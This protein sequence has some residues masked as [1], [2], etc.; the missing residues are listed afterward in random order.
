MATFRKKRSRKYKRRNTRRNTR[1]NRR[2]KKSLVGGVQEEVQEEYKDPEEPKISLFFGPKDLIQAITQIISN[3]GS[4]EQHFRATN[5]IRNMKANIVIYTGQFKETLNN[6]IIID[7][8]REKETFISSFDS[9]LQNVTAKLDQLYEET[10]FRDEASIIEEA[11]KLGIDYYN[12]M[13]TSLRNIFNI[14]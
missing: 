11:R 4:N 10:S 12:A 6:N 9:A 2:S 3:G 13:L 7:D 8:K 1:R 14:Y 5:F